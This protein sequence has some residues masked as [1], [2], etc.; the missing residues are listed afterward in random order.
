MQYADFEE[1]LRTA[2]GLTSSPVS[3]SILQTEAEVA[4]VAGTHLPLTAHRYC[5]ALMRARRG[6]RVLV[7]SEGLNCPAAAAA[8]GFRPLPDKLATGE[9]LVGFGIVQTPEQGR[10]MFESMTRFSPGSVAGIELKPLAMAER[11]PDVVVVEGEVEQLMWLLLANLHLTGQRQTASTAV[12][13]ATCVDS[14]VIPFHQGQLNFSFG[15]Y[16]CREATDMAASEAVIGFPGAVLEPI[17]AAI[18]YLAAKAIPRS[19]AKRVFETLRQG[20]VQRPCH[21]GASDQ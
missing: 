20:D 15:C 21:E 18:T 3:V 19:R 1:C 16:G 7:T 11:P 12:L 4:Q 9:G 5:Q 6:Q 13:Q 17:V 8:F 10:L 2:L 14:T